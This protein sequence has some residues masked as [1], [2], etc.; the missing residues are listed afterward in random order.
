MFRDNG[1]TTALLG[2]FFG[3][4]FLLPV[5]HYSKSVAQRRLLEQIPAEVQAAMAANQAAPAV[6]PAA[7][8]PAQAAAP[9]NE[10]ASATQASQTVAVVAAVPA[11]A[12]PVAGDAAKGKALYGTCAGCHGRDGEGGR[13]FNSPRLSG[14]KDWYLKRQLVK[15]KDGVRGSH[16]QDVFGMQMAPMAKL[17]ADEAAV[18]NVVAYMVTLQPAKGTDKGSGVADKGEPVYALCLPCHGDQAQGNFQQKAPTLNNQHAWYLAKQLANFKTGVRG[19]HPDDD[20][21]KLMNAIAKTLEDE[22][23]IDN[24]IAYIQSFSGE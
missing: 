16:P 5:H 19:E 2:I 22:K 6:T 11:V 7:A 20:E 21:G 4:V 23:S 14:Q 10:A 8:P 9:A 17:L 1:I 3:L 15:F 12:P 18:D 24:I 13:M